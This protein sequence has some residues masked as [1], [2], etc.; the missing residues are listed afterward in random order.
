MYVLA[1]VRDPRRGTRF[2]P[3]RG[4]PSLNDMLFNPSLPCPPAAAYSRE[5]SIRCG[6]PADLKGLSRKC[7]G[8]G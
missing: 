8:F 1:V 7:F 5:P 4:A 3:K 2:L 6:R